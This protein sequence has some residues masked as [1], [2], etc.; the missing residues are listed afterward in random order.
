MDTRR[1]ITNNST[2]P[3]S[4][5]SYP[6]KE[7][8]RTFGE[9]K[10]QPRDNRFQP[11]GE[12]FQDK[13]NRFPKRDS[14]FSPRND[15]F[16]PKGR[17]PAK[18]KPIKPWQKDNRPRL[19]SDLQITD[20]KHRGKYLQTSPM[21]NVQMTQRRV[22]ET[23]FKILY[24]RIRARRFLDLCA[25][26]GAIGVEAISRGAIIGTFVERS[27]RLCSLIKKNLET[28][29]IKT[30]HGE[31]VESEV[32]PFL[33][34]MAKRRRFWDVVFFNPSPDAE[35]EEI[36]KYLSRGAGIKPKGILVIEH[37]SD[38]FF[39]ERIGVMKR[40]RVVVQGETTLS[41]YDRQL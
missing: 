26:T 28:C 37:H 5:N 32:V 14:R 33:K 20:G 17:F 23:L 3:Y 31:V 36:L 38:V 30:G 39:P 6:K 9:R 34:K 1:Q 15:R 12:R 18:G 29:G 11:R 8:E 35:T 22:R 2:K 19:V 24:K 16:Q 25:G 21:Q 13:D 10:Y 27:A 41:F 4:R 40:W 7:G